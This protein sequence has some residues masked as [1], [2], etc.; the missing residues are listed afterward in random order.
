MCITSS[1]IP[2]SVYFSFTIQ[3]FALCGSNLQECEIPEHR[4][5]R[6]EEFILIP[7]DD[8]VTDLREHGRQKNANL[9]AA[10][11]LDE[12]SIA[13]VFLQRNIVFWSVEFE[14]VAEGEEGLPEEPA[15]NFPES[16]DGGNEG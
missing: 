11:R 8:F 9:F 1:K 13:G 5:I 15:P 12:R 2:S 16:F 10:V 7:I 14:G 3:N 4:V 6:R